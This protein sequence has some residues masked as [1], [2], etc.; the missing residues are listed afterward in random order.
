MGARK[1]RR[2]SGFTI[3]ELMVT[4][5]II[6]ILASLAIPRYSDY[7]RRASLP[8]AFSRLGDLRIKLEQFYQ[9][10]RSYGTGACGNDGSSNTIDFAANA[11]K[12][13]ITCQLTGTSAVDQAY[14]LTATGS[15]LVAGHV[16]TLDSSNNK[17]TLSF[18]GK[19]STAACWL[20]KG[21][22]C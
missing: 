5:A 18:K 14:L 21:D 15:G 1:H 20:V 6:G 12:F 13:A 19:T 22:E 9:S 11:N 8:E 2:L 7:L 16:Y 10:N 3:V 4:L 17:R